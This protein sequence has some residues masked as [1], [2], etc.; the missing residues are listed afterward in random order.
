VFVFDV[1]KVGGNGQY[2]RNISISWEKASE[3]PIIIIIISK[4]AK[5]HRTNDVNGKRWI[6]NEER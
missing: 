6:K 1:L 3:R 2:F 4:R 5:D